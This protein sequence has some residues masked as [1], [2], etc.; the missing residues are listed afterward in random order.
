MDT[1]WFFPLSLV[2]SPFFFI[3]LRLGERER[4]RET[5]SLI[6]PRMMRTLSEKKNFF[7]SHYILGRKVRPKKF[8]VTSNHHE[9][10][11]RTHSKARHDHVDW[12]NAIAAYLAVA[13]IN[14]LSLVR[15]LSNFHLWILQHSSPFF[16]DQIIVVLLLNRELCFS[17]SP[18]NVKRETD[19]CTTRHSP[20]PPQYLLRECLTLTAEIELS[21]AN[22]RRRSPTQS[23]VPSSLSLSLSQ[24][25]M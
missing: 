22:G 8:G 25:R 24:A 6:F 10:V 19:L 14:W 4:E 12:D 18:M 5:Y 13:D 15:F 21:R 3:L 2:H 23:V 7:P 20:F 16:A 1:A 17:R 9:R 11:F